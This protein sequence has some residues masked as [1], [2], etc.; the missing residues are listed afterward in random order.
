MTQLPQLSHER[1][2]RMLV[3][4]AEYV[5]TITAA[6][7]TRGR[8]LARGDETAA[9]FGA[10][11]LPS[12]LPTFLE[13][14]RARTVRAIARIPFAEV[15]ADLDEARR[16]EGRPVVFV[17]P[18]QCVLD[19]LVTMVVC[20]ALSRKIWL[21]AAAPIVD[22]APVLKRLGCFAVRRD[23]PLATARQLSTIGTMARSQWNR[24][25]VFFPEAGHSRLGLPVA[26]ER[27]VLS[28]ARA[29]KAPIV[30]VAIAYEHFERARPF[31]Y[32]RAGAP[33]EVV[34]ARDIDLR[35]LLDDAQAAL[36]RDL[37][38][39]SGSYRPLVR[40][41]PRMLLHHNL[42]LDTRRV[43]RSC[44]PHYRALTSNLQSTPTREGRHHDAC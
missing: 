39:G 9:D 33:V 15:F 42:P 36:V 29:A 31:V 1:L 19:A 5:M 20:D 17:L 10:H 18:H 8:K 40:H 25:I 3:E 7:L 32:V 37:H 38:D 4:H 43:G 35:G 11:A 2:S 21:A 28:V 6:R 41:D 27:G 34:R 13:P 22:R 44:G 14:T 23:H 16:A 30:P 12:L 24:G 26:P